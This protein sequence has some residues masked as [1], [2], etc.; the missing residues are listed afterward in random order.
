[1]IFAGLSSI[2]G[3]VAAADARVCAWAGA[4][5]D[6]QPHRSRLAIAA[7]P[8]ILLAFTASPRQPETIEERQSP[9]GI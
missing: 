6:M 2:A 4:W 8:A 1:L 5:A 9:R 3:L 7:K